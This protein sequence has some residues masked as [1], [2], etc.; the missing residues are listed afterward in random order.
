M[1]NLIKERIISC[2]SPKFSFMV[3]D[4]KGILKEINPNAL[5]IEIDYEYHKDTEYFIK[6]FIR[7]SSIK[8][9]CPILFCA[10]AYASTKEFPEDEYYLDETLS[11]GDNRKLLPI[12]NI[13]ERDSEIF[14]NCG[15]ININNWINYKHKIAFLYP[16]DIGMEVYKVIQKLNLEKSLDKM[17]PEISEDKVSIREEK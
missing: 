1:S 8:Y 2:N 3:E 4:L 6:E 7:D 11:D 10:T 12:K 15:F 5:I 14:I 17:F 13:L 16:N 9:H